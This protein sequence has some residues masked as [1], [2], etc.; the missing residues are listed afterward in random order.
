M[1]LARPRRGL[2][3]SHRHVD[4]GDRVAGAAHR[5]VVI[6]GLVAVLAFAGACPHVVPV[7]VPVVVAVA[8]AHVDV[9]VA[10]RGSQDQDDQLLGR[11]VV[12]LDTADG[13]RLRRVPI[14]RGARGEGQRLRRD[15]GGIDV[16]AVVVQADAGL[17]VLGLDR[18]DG[19]V[20]SGVGGEGEGER[21]RRSFGD[22]EIEVSGAARGVQV[23]TRQIHAGRRVADL[24][25]AGRPGVEL[26]HLDAVVVG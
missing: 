15:G 12:V 22:G 16:P 10:L 13:H 19:G 5:T 24:V 26:E 11:V 17:V 8:L 6:D 23:R 18:D 25:C 2:V 14:A 7:R 3:V 20:G 9:I 4:P 1:Q 21:G